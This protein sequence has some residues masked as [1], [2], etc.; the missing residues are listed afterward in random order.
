[1]TPPVSIA[2]HFEQTADIHPSRLAVQTAMCQLSYAELNQ[3]ASRL[4]EGI[5]SR[6]QHV[7][8]IAL[9]L[10]D[11]VD[12]ITAILGALKAGKTYV[13]IAPETPPSRA[14]YI[15]EDSGAELVVTRARHL[16]SIRQLLGDDAAVCAIEELDHVTEAAAAPAD[17][18]PDRP[19]W[20]LYTSGSTGRPKGVVQTHRNILNYVQTYVTGYSLVPEDR[21]ALLFS[22]TANAG[23]HELFSAILTGASVIPYDVATAGVTALPAWLARNEI[24]ILSCVPTLFRR[25]VDTLSGTVPLP[26]IRIVKMVGEPVY[27]RDVIAYRKFFSP[28]ATFINRLGSTE[29]GTIRWHFVDH[30][31]SI[32][33]V[34]VPVGYPVPD[35]EVLVVDETR[36]PVAGMEVGEIAVRS[37]F[38]S[39]GYWNQPDVTARAFTPPDEDERRL[40]L[41]GD[42]GYMHP[43]GC[44]VHVGRK[45]DQVKIRGYRIE[46]AEVQSAL[47][48]L[49]AIKE[50]IVLAR[51][52]VSEE[53]Q[54]IAY[55]IPTE[56]RPPTTSSLRHTLEKTIPSYMIPSAFVFMQSFPLAANGKILRSALPPP[57]S[58]PELDTPFL[59]PRT[60]L[61][62]EIATIWTAVLDVQPI[63][64]D[65]PFLELGGDSLRAARLV[66]RVRSKLRVEIPQHMLVDGGT[67]A[68]MALVVERLRAR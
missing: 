11:E 36:T 38:L 25:L 30:T 31:T 44:L 17:I 3:R 5:L 26:G 67:V 55:I 16:E 37:R 56:K 46:L 9:L 43:D 59:A 49:P 40:F 21:V 10:D 35:H 54:L 15:R 39:P 32:E 24:S 28:N 62:E 48:D 50:A 45:D 60:T 63:G 33:G 19:V 41:T 51:K 57:T 52:D 53:P 64:V 58:R 23:G 8:R 47:L 66:N 27:R 22:L 12:M 68:R 42:L 7:S 6:Y 13:P 29:T 1:M 4:S 61:E 2:A 20:I 18:Q 65:D 14:R 34:H